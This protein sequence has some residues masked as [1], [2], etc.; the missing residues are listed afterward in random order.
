MSAWKYSLFCVFFK[1]PEILKKLIVIVILISSE[2]YFISALSAVHSLTETKK[3]IDSFVWIFFYFGRRLWKYQLKFEFSYTSAPWT[4]QFVVFTQTL[5]LCF[6][7]FISR[8]EMVPLRKTE[9]IAN[10]HN[11]FGDYADGYQRGWAVE[12]VSVANW[13]LICICETKEQRKLLP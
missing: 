1:N 12:Y 9:S 6:P 13:Q 5:S 10:T 11:T 2:K 8:F 3:E 4:L 7:F